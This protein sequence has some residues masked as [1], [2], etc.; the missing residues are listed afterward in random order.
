[1]L[2]TSEKRKFYRQTMGA[3]AMVMCVNQI[4]GSTAEQKDAQA[5]EAVE[6]RIMDIS[7]GGVRLQSKKDVAFQ[8]GDWLLFST[9]NPL[10]KGPNLNYT[11]RVQRVNELSKAYE[12]G[13]EFQGLTEEER[14]PLLRLVMALQ[15]K[16][17]R[18]RRRRDD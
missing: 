3:P 10:E 12:Y 17:L 5:I 15:Q 11:C 13:C 18:T 1:M 16:E 6:C 7:G 9:E 14:E 8:V 4:F 2:Q